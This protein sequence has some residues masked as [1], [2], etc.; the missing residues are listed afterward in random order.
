LYRRHQKRALHRNTGVFFP[1]DPSINN[2]D[3]QPSVEAELHAHPNTIVELP[4]SNNP[5]ELDAT[6]TSSPNANNRTSHV[7]LGNDISPTA[8]PD[9]NN[10][11]SAI[12]TDNNARWS[13]V[14]SLSSPRTRSPTPA[15]AL[16]ATSQQHYGTGQQSY[17]LPPE[18]NYRPYRPFS[19]APPT[20]QVSES[21]IPSILRPGSA[22]AVEHQQSVDHPPKETYAGENAEED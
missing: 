2:P 8:S 10:R 5:G 15:P 4:T 14:S 19:P 11:V 17:L 18:T 22:A 16:Q 9:L 20:I 12:S 7:A 21:E 1:P 3:T 13:A 6:P